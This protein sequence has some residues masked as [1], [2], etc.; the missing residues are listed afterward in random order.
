MAKKT[1]ITVQDTDVM[2][3]TG[4]SQD[5]FSLT[6]IARRVNAE[7]PAAIV[8]NWLRL[9]D[10]IEFLGT[11]EIIH[12]PDFNLIEFDKV[13]GEAGTNRFILS[14]SKWVET[15]GAIGINT[16]AGRY[17]GGT[18]AHQD[19]ALAFCYWVSPTFQLYLIKEFQRL[20][21]QEAKDQVE[22]L[23]WNLRRTLAKVNYRIHADAVKMHLIPPRLANSKHEGIIYASQA[24]ILNL[25]LF[26]VTARQWREANPD[27]KGNIRDYATTE[28]LLV[29]VNL[30]NLN[31]HFIQEGLAPD[32]RLDKLNEIAI[33][34]MQLLSTPAIAAG[35]K[36]L[37]DKTK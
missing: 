37:T 34:Q 12:N 5:Y 26:G 20:K 29:L 35:M 16:K 27:L 10:T 31:A 25:A 33:H 2:I 17:G 4:E 28:Q 3:L 8:I 36:Q 7:N 1:T 30:E 22:A 9:K 14:V 21:A 24:D 18:F 23:G 6:D 13:K 32:E 19:I 15:T 11:W